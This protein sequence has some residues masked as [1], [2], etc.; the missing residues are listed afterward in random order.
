[1]SGQTDNDVFPLDDEQ[2]KLITLSTS[3]KRSVIA[4]EMLDHLALPNSCGKLYFDTTFS[5]M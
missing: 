3:G 2:W 5:K 4:P 1:L